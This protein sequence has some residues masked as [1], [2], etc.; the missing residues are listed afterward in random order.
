MCFMHVVRE[1]FG[2]VKLH[3]IIKA[4]FAHVVK[5]DKS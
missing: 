1:P 4:E 3:M 5:L 2:S